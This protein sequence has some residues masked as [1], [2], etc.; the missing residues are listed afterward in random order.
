MLSKVF[1][2]TQGKCCGRKCVMCPY[3]NKHNG[4]SKIVRKEVIDTL[5]KWEKKELNL[6]ITDSKS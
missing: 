6:F 1:L 5:E 3:T 4:T 2:I